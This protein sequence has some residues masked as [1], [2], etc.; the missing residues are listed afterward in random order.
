MKLTL[1][2]NCGL[3]VAFARYL[4]ILIYLQYC[5]G[6]HCKTALSQNAVYF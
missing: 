1:S 6:M 3:N 2:K 4:M 5:E